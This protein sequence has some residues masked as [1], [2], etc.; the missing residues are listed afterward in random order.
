MRI[1]SFIFILFF[2]SSC[3]SNYSDKEIATF[4]QV[5]QEY[6]DSAEISMDKTEEGM[7]YTIIEEGE[8]EDFISHKDQV[9]F[10]YTAS[11]LGGNSFQMIDENDPLIYNVG[12]L[13]YGWQDALMMLKKGGR[14]KIIIPP[15]L[16]Y[17]K[18][19][20]GLIQPSTIL[21]YDLT[22]MDVK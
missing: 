19:K 1:L 10:Y 2:L 20:T 16:G 7:Y 12:Q 22:V 14:I 11:F 8:G 6:L 18:K 4:D 17:G 5:I 13:I 21:Q 9:T 15:Q 3:S